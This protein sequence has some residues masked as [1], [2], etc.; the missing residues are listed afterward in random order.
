MIGRPKL[1]STVILL[2][3]FALLV[4]TFMNAYLFLHDDLAIL[5]S[6]E[7]VPLFGEALGQLVEVSSRVIYLAVMG[8]IGAILTN[9]GIQLYQ[10]LD[11]SDPSPDP[12]PKSRVKSVGKSTKKSKSSSPGKSSSKSPQ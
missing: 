2:V 12:S 7:F 8:W 4:F 3:G 11:V 6:G 5:T 9:R 10:K 1:L